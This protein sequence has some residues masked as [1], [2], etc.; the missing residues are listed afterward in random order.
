MKTASTAIFSIPASAYVRNV[1]TIWL[2]RYGLLMLLPFLII[3]V[4]G[5]TVDTAFF[6]V[7]LMLLFLLYPAVLMMV[8]YNY[9]LTTEAR[10][11]ITAHDV[12]FTS[13]RL[14][15][16]RYRTVR[17]KDSDTPRHILE[18]EDSVPASDIRGISFQRRYMLLRLVGKKISIMLIPLD[19]IEGITPGEIYDIADNYTKKR[20]F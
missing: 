11:E 1:I 14:R 17:D 18:S 10:A 2:Q 12:T 4:L 9:A 19:S 3:A 5:F 13:G 8:Y 16:R 20:P 7:A 6:F 15:I